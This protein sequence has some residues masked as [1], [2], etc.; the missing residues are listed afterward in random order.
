[1]AVYIVFLFPF[2]LAGVY[3][4]YSTYC[5]AVNFQTARKMGIPLVIIPVSPENPIW[6]LLGNRITSICEHIFGESHFTRFSIRGWV[7]YDKNRAALE[8]G[9]HFAFV[10]PD[11]VW[12]YVCNAATLT[13]VIRRRNDFPRPLELLGKCNIT[14]RREWNLTKSPEMLNV[15]GPNVSTVCSCHLASLLSY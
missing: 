8:L 14:L 6:M 13:E 1:M 9:D 4:T 15:F 5:L 2:L 3:I 11:K 7:Y 12:F 10:T